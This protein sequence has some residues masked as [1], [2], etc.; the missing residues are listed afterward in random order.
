[1]FWRLRP[2]IKSA[3][4]YNHHQGQVLSPGTQNFVFEP[5]FELPTF[6]IA[7]GVA[8]LQQL[9][10]LSPPQI[11]QARSIPVAGIGG[12]TAGQMALQGLEE[13]ENNDSSFN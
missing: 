13:S 8:N 12:L 3:A 1:M 5:G 2:R 7:S 6:P 4:V 9:R 10:P 11:Y